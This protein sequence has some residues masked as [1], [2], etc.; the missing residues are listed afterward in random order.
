[1]PVLR[2]RIHS[3]NL[4]DDGS[5]AE[6][7]HVPVPM[8]NEPAQHSGK[9]SIHGSGSATKRHSMSQSRGAMNAEEEYHKSNS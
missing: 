5:I 2:Q 8:V 1:M 7:L 3:G 6:S 4:S 9:A